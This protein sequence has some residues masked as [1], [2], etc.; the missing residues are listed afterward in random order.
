[1]GKTG[2]LKFESTTSQ[3]IAGLY[4]KSKKILLPAYLFYAAQE[5]YEEIRIQ[6]AGKWQ[7]VPMP[8]IREF[9]IP[10]PPLAMQIATVAELEA[11][12]A[13]VAAN[14]QLII[15]L[16]QKIQLALSSP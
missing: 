14:R 8:F 3:N 4:P 9:Q 15:R 6:G 7:K 16:E 11:E 13:L 10:L 12:Q 1:M 2:I 5:L